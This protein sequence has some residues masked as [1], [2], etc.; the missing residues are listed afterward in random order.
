MPSELTT[1]YR[2]L[3][4]AGNRA[5]EGLR[6]C[7][8]YVR[9]VLDDQGLTTQLKKLRHDLAEVA[10][11]WPQELLDQS[12]DIAHDVGTD[13]TL[14]SEMQRIDA[15]DVCAAS[16]QRTKQALRTLEEFGK[17]IAPPAA[18]RLEQL[19]YE[20]YAV[21][22]A[23]GIVRHARRRLAHVSLCVL[24]D[25]G[26]SVEA[27]RQLAAT[28]AAAGVGMIQLRDKQLDGDA[29]V[30]RARAVRDGVAA[31]TQPAD[32]TLVIV[33]DRVDIAAAV[34]ADGVHLGQ[35]DLSI[36]DARRVLGPRAILGRSTHSIE[37]ARA[38]QQQGANYLGVGPIYPS[39]T[40]QFADFPG[41]AFA[42]EVAAEI[43]LP[44]LA[45]GGI[46]L[47]NIAEL[48]AAGAKRVAIR[49]AIVEADDPA[50]AARRALD[51]LSATTS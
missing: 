41:L 50:A 38:A 28:L 6:V 36:R 49:S 3:D 15:A 19:R 24:I 46:D 9:L 14:D 10:R 51:A 42:R 37:Q 22:A 13:I 23:V 35:D 2:V 12:R 4:A 33:N 16:F 5:A 34:D 40:K 1:L 39:R 48:K 29:L 47:E 18:A 25:G 27:C 32:R 20:L 30:G 21:E 7:E 45:I 8:D 26:S 44:W 31:A 43:S 17:L 11:S